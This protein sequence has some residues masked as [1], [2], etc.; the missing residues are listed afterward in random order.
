M[1]SRGPSRLSDIIRALKAC[2]GGITFELKKH[3]YWVYFG[4]KTFR[5]LPK[6]KG[7]G[8]ADPEIEF[9]H[10]A[11]LCRMIGVDLACVEGQLGFRK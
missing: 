3:H 5:G 6:G 8:N 10:V 4:G 9:G 2:A 11:K 1:T 7:H